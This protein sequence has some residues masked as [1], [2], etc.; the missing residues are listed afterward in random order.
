MS[1]HTP[2]QALLSSDASS[3]SKRKGAFMMRADRSTTKGEAEVPTGVT[4]SHILHQTSEM[5]G[6]SARRVLNV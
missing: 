4:R 5:R 2:S 1:R 6:T 3:V